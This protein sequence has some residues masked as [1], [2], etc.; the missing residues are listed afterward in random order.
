[1]KKEGPAGETVRSKGAQFRGK[2]AAKGFAEK[3]KKEKKSHLPPKDAKLMRQGL[4]MEETHHISEGVKKINKAKKRE[5][6]TKEGRKIDASTHDANPQISK[7]RALAAAR[8]STGTTIERTRQGV[9]ALQRGRFRDAERESRQDEVSHISEGEQRL[10][11]VG[12]AAVKSKKPGLLDAARRAK[13]KVD[14][15]N[16]KLLN[17]VK[18]DRHKAALLRNREGESRQDEVRKYFDPNKRR[19]ERRLRGQAMKAKAD[20]P[21]A[22]QDLGKAAKVADA[23]AEFRK[24]QIQRNQMDDS[25]YPFK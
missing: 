12:R 22:L 5:F 3:M 4:T 2:G 6:Q 9:A 13:L 25:K 18:I 15:R 14:R 21:K 11:R 8:H 17:T 16:E 23:K 10:L 7:N 19:T 20:N 1:V 24:K